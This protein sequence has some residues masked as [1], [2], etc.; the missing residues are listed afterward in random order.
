MR[1]LGLSKHISCSSDT[2]LW[3]SAGTAP[4]V[5]TLFRD[6]S[7]K[8]RFVEVAIWQ[9]WVWFTKIKLDD[10]YGYC[11][12]LRVTPAGLKAKPKDAFKIPHH[13]ARIRFALDVLTWERLQGRCPDLPPETQ[14]SLTHDE[15]CQVWAGRLQRAVD[16][17]AER[18]HSVYGPPEEIHILGGNASAAYGRVSSAKYIVPETRNPIPQTSMHVP[19]RGLSSAESEEEIWQRVPVTICE[20]DATQQQVAL[21]GLL[22]ATYFKLKHVSAPGQDPLAR[23]W[24]RGGEIYMWVPKGGRR[25]DELPRDIL[26]DDQILARAARDSIQ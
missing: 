6:P 8:G 5:A 25:E 3:M 11:G 22:Y 20:R 18:F 1:A 23:G 9:S 2:C 15:V 4:A 16:A 7:G 24:T 13:Q 26:N 21:K 12:G 17:L 19:N 10:P 14:P